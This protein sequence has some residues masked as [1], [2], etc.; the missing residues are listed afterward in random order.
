MVNLGSLWASILIGFALSFIV[1]TVAFRRAYLS[2]SGALAAVLVG[3]VTF[4]LGGP[5]F[6]VIL[7]AFF[8]SSSLL[9]HLQIDRKRKV[10]QELAQGPRRDVWQVMANGG[11][12]VLLAALFYW[13]PSHWVSWAFVGSLAAVTADTW[14]TEIGTLS[15][16]KPR[17]ITTGRPV[18]PGTSGAVSALGAVA[19]FLGSLFTGLVASITLAMMA[20]SGPPPWMMLGVVVAGMAG[21]LADSILGATAQVAYVCENCETSTESATH[22]CGSRTTHVRGLYW[23]NNDVVNLLCSVV[24]ATVAGSMAIWL[25]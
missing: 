8:V 14:A 9:S 2:F 22:R 21:S 12:A 10:A 3:T 13:N 16:T 17:L 20:P 19:A 18:S 23:V 24:G 15:G 4:G 11:L 5:S 25:A 6:A 7:V 1:A